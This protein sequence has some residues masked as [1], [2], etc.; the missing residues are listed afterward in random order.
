MEQEMIPARNKTDAHAQDFLVNEKLLLL[1]LKAFAYCTCALHVPRNACYFQSVF[2]LVELLQIAIQSSIASG[3]PHRARHDQPRGD[4]LVIYELYITI[5]E[6]YFEIT[7]SINM[8]FSET[9]EAAVPIYC[10]HLF[11]LSMST[12]NPDSSTKLT[13]T[14]TQEVT[15]RILLHV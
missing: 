11:V 4:H 2:I 9:A 3:A 6:G 10:F 5:I 8:Q 1:V 13:H 14:H 15:S 12:N 7:G